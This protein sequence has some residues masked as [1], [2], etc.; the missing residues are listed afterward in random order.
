MTMS[1]ISVGTTNACVESFG[2]KSLIFNSETVCV[3]D[4]S[5]C[6]MLVSSLPSM[7][8]VNGFGEIFGG[9]VDRDEIDGNVPAGD[10]TL[11]GLAEEFA[12][13]AVTTFTLG[14]T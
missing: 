5:S 10:G 3:A 1:V 2:V 14:C 9:E 11:P 7:V 12:G 6:A 8:M 4:S 13:G